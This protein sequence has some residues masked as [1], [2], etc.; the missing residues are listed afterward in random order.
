MVL[1]FSILKS[2]PLKLTCS[3]EGFSAYNNLRPHMS[4]NYF[5]PEQMH[6]QNKLEN[7]E[8]KNKFPKKYRP[9]LEPL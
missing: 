8:W 4:C 5:T 7:R 6:L 1:S 3:R 9:F 2:M